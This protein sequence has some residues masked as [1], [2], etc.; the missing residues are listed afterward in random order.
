LHLR[1]TASERIRHRQGRPDE[2]LEL[3]LAGFNELRQRLAP[4]EHR[5]HRSVL[6]YNAAQVLAALERHDEAIA[7]ISRAMA[8]DPNYSEYYAERGGVYLKIGRFEEAERDFLRA[9]DLSP[10]YS[11]VWT[12]LGQCYRVTDRPEEAIRAY[13]RA[14]DLDP[15]VP[16]ALI[17]RAESSLALGDADGAIRDYT[18]ALALEH[19]QPLVLAGR[20]VAY[21]ESGRF[22]D[23]LNDNRRVVSES[24]R[25]VDRPGPARRGAPGSAEVSGAGPDCARSCRRRATDRSARCA[26]KRSGSLTVPGYASRASVAWGLLPSSV[27][28]T[29]V[30]SAVTHQPLPDIGTTDTLR[31]RGSA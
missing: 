27:M 26:G 8:L 1:A 23:A 9:I 30:R 14:L 17:G 11:D 18:A 24:G 10:P 4:E 3:C 22:D 31:L 13:A 21:Y 15:A 28:S 5:L 16:L 7:C 2:A 19:E 29:V 6:L 20:A 25:G 12:N